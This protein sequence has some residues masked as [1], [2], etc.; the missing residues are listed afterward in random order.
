[1]DIPWFE[2]Y[3]ASNYWNIKSLK[4][5][6]ERILQTRI[7]KGYERITIWINGKGYN[8]SI[9]RLVMLAFI[10]ESTLEVNHKKNIRDF[11]QKRH[12]FQSDLDLGKEKIKILTDQIRNG[13]EIKEDKKKKKEEKK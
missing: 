4:C 5:N 7:D 10:W 3:Q 11:K 6:K 13:V 2:W 1:M 12:E 9:H 8:R